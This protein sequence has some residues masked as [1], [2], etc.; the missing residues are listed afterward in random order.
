MDLVWAGGVV[1]PPI[2]S[3]VQR[4]SLL[5]SGSTL[6]LLSTTERGV[7][8]EFEGFPDLFV[9]DSRHLHE[10]MSTRDLPMERVKYI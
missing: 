9:Q 8:R 6:E 7:L 5:I 1:S 2:A 3:P 10:L 4:E